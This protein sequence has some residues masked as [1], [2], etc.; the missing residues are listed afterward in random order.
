MITILYPSKNVS[1]LCMLFSKVIIVDHQNYFKASF[2]EVKFEKVHKMSLCVKLNNF[3]TSM[4]RY[5][6]YCFNY[7]IFAK[8]CHLSHFFAIFSVSL[9]GPEPP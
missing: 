4:V 8:C 1:G 9:H 5:H 7:L 6:F 2:S 3:L